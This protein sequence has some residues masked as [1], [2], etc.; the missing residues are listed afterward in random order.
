MKKLTKVVLIVLFAIACLFTTTYATSV[1]AASDNA[2]NQTLQ[3]ESTGKLLEIKKHE[4]TTIEDYKVKYGSDTYGV[5]AYILDR[6][7]IYSIPLVFIGLAFS[8]IY[9]YV[10]GLKRMDMRDKGF[11]SMIAIITI[12]VICQILPIIFAIVVTSTEN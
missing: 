5:T 9:Q 3:G 12:G 2:T 7:R 1:Y 8:A 11:Y 10:I 6:V 4:L